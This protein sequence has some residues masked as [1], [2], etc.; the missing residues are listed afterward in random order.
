MGLCKKLH[1]KVCEG[2]RLTMAEKRF[3]GIEPWP[4]NKKKDKRNPSPKK[5]KSAGEFVTDLLKDL[6]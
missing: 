6:L 4:Q 5:E 2:S 3:G 1:T